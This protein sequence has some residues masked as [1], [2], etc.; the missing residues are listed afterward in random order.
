MINVLNK[1]EIVSSIHGEWAGCNVVFFEETGSTNV[2]ARMLAEQ[3]AGHGT[4]V[5]AD[6]Q[7]GGKGRRGRSWHSPKGSAIAMSMIL[8]PELEPDKASMLTLVQAMA[9]AKA[10]EE[11]CGCKP[12]IKWPNDILINEKKVCGILT[13]MNLNKTEIASIII[14]CGVNV[15]QESFPEE[16]SQI[17]TSLKMETGQMF[18][19]AELIGCI[20][21]YFEEYFEEFMTAKDLSGIVEKYNN[22]LISKGCSVKVLDPQGEFQ[23]EALGINARGELLVKKESG[24]IVNVYA[25]EVSVRGIYGYV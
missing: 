23:G 25:G 11:I 16:I 19:R 4:L 1:Q 3:G 22:Y 12:Q 6:S 5:V 14:G 7:S 20:C 13:E 17:A 2:E 18:H 15:N 21:R 24:E 9:V 8:K 10:L